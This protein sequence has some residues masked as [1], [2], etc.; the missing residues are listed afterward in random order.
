MKP[1]KHPYHFEG[2]NFTVE[3]INALLA[4]IPDKANR[5]EVRDGLSAYEVAVKHGYQG[6]EE[7]WLASL[8]GKTGEPLTYADLTPEQIEEL[9]LP[10]VLAA[11]HLKTQTDE[12]VNNMN[13][14]GEDIREQT[15]DALR[16]ATEATAQAQEEAKKK[17]YPSVDADGNLQWRQSDSDTPPAPVNI[18]GPAGNDGL[19]GD[20]ADLIVVK[21]LD[22]E[23][24]E[25]GKSYALGASVG[26]QLKQNIED[27][28][29]LRTNTSVY[30]VSRFHR[31]TGYWEAVTYDAGAELYSSTKTYNENAVVNLANYTAYSFR[32]V[33]S[34][35]GVEPDYE[36]I[37]DKF[38]LEEAV[39]F[40]PQDLRVT[41]MEVEFLNKEE[42][43]PVKY[44]FNGGTWGDVR[45]W[46]YDL[47][48]K[49]NHI[50]NNLKTIQEWHLGYIDNSGEYHSDKNFFI[51]KTRCLP[52]QKVTFY[53]TINTGDKT[54]TNLFLT[55]NNEIVSKTSCWITAKEVTSI[56]TPNNAFY[57]IIN[58]RIDDVSS[59]YLNVEDDFLSSINQNTEA[60][61]LNYV[62]TPNHYLHNDGIR[63]MTGLFLVK[64]RCIGG[65]KVTFYNTISE[66]SKSALYGFFKDD[67]TKISSYSSYLKPKQIIVITVPDESDYILISGES[68]DIS[69]FYL[70][71]EDDFLSPINQNTE[72]ISLLQYY[73]PNT[74]WDVTGQ[75]RQLIG[76]FTTIT[77]CM[78]GQKVIFYNTIDSQSTTV[79]AV[80]F[81]LDRSSVIKSIP[82]HVKPEQMC[83]EIVPNG[84]YYFGLSGRI[85]K[86]S[87]YY[88]NI[89]NLDSISEKLSFY[90]DDIEGFIPNCYY[91]IKDSILTKIENS[92]FFSFRKR[93]TSNQ[94]ITFYNT[95]SE[96]SKTPMYT[97]LKEDGITIVQT[98]NLW[99]TAKTLISLS[100][101]KDAFYFLF[102]GE[103]SDI[104]RFYFNIE[105][106]FK[107]EI[108]TLYSEVSVLRSQIGAIGGNPFQGKVIYVSGDSI[109][110]GA[111]PDNIGKGYGGIIADMYDATLIQR[112]VSGATLRTISDR[113]C[114]PA[115]VKYHKD[116]DGKELSSADY[117][118]LEGGLND[119]FFTTEGV[120]ENKTW[121]GELSSDFEQAYAGDESI[122]N[123]PNTIYDRLDFY[124]SFVCRNAKKTAKIV[125]IIVWKAGN[126]YKMVEPGDNNTN[127]RWQSVYQAIL[128]TCKKY[129]VPVVDLWAECRA[130]A[131]IEPYKQYTNNNDGT[132]PSVE[133]YNLFWIN[134]IIQKL[135]EI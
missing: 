69:K 56:L 55:D 65:Q 68:N 88:L 90:L 135:L 35:T 126:L 133:G 1:P 104:K 57:V 60:I 54:V 11:E 132:H 97:F 43:S 122:E 87:S 120:P 28:K 99:T 4:S 107:A 30:C 25:Q 39:Y 108:N 38:T 44:R 74:Y 59:F 52:N 20:T 10:A 17:W 41:G 40:V 46:K 61:S 64:K 26:P 119:I 96:G 27:T 66:G 112:A 124:L 34:Q 18:K 14:L 45:N 80:F 13:R 29:T 71:V 102:S 2:L 91:V 93:C 23:G 79:N 67:G 89:L 83:S 115:Y 70:N 53:N 77:R 106:D 125:Y 42:N 110:Y 116:D 95:I 51:I 92:G 109:A 8:R 22:G 86:R 58:G 21:N 101:P 50:M 100:V 103:T 98:G 72:A 12:A 81:G 134:P 82:L 33:K 117:I 118:L 127:E 36:A 130:I 49:T 6:T 84:A 3:E 63:E 121:L 105:D 129:G 111:A 76:Y 123:I 131:G 19:T 128:R 94:K 75:Q 113:A 78:G 114:I 16:Q 37:T 73:V 32:S 9:Q 31:H 7:Q 48:E 62:Y 15:S 5:N 24:A 47:Y 85:E